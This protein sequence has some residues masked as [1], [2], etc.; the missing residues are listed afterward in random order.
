[1]DELVRQNSPPSDSFFAGPDEEGDAMPIDDTGARSSPSVPQT[2][3]T[4]SSH[5][6]P[7]QEK[8][9][10]DD[11]DDEVVITEDF[12]TLKRSQAVMMEDTSDIEIIEQT[13]KADFDP[14]TSNLHLSLS[15]APKRKGSTQT[16]KRRRVT[17]Q[18]EVTEP[19]SGLLPAYLGE[20]LVPNAWSTISGSGY[21]KPNDIIR[22]RRDQGD[23]STSVK[24]KSKSFNSK[25]KMDNKKQ[26][27]LTSMI[28]AQPQKFSKKKRP[29]TIVRL[30]TKDD[31]G[32]FFFSSSGA[33]HCS[34]FVEFGRLPTETS[35]WVSKLLELGQPYCA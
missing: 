4:F 7:P 19:S 10:L 17:P 5:S 3:K 16:Q 13:R 22:V 12:P 30:V 26:V 32:T 6:S 28:G 25:K 9:F 21:V 31:V 15:P 11:S 34:P 8:L 33:S 1:M 27:T 14:R 2:P 20:V 18:T 23:E 29:D 35:W 24:L